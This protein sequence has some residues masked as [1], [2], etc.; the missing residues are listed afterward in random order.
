VDR[1]IG[2]LWM[3]YIWKYQWIAVAQTRFQND[4]SEISKMIQIGKDV[5]FIKKLIQNQHKTGGSKF[6]YKRHSF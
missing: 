1:G 3:V 4:A 5:N 6:L 2:D